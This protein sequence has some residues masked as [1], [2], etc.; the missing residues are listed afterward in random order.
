MSGGS[1]LTLAGL[2]AYT[3]PTR[4]TNLYATGTDSELSLPIFISIS[5]TAPNDATYVEAL[6]GGDLELPMVTQI[7]GTV[8]LESNGPPKRARLVRT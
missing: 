2:T 3:D 7:T 5:S 4:F 6:A 8:P 1:S